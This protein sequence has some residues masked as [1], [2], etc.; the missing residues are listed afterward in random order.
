MGGSDSDIQ[1][2]VG[3]NAWN[4]RHVEDTA[5]LDSR[6]RPV[7]LADGSDRWN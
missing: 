7:C 3:V 2:M 4:Q 1:C 5:Y 6:R